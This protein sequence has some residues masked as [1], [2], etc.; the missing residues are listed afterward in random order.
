MVPAWQG[1]CRTPLATFLHGAFHS[2]LADRSTAMA[3]THR[4]KKLLGALCIGLSVLAALAVLSYTPSDNA[5]VMA[6]FEAGQM[7]HSVGVQNWLGLVG[8]ALAWA[9][10]PNFLGYLAVVPCILIGVVGWYVVRHRSLKPLTP[11][12][13]N[14]L[15]GAFL[16]AVFLGWMGLAFDLSTTRWAGA[17]GSAVAQAFVQAIGIPGTFL[18]IAGVA[19]VMGLFLAEGTMRGAMQRAVRSAQTARTSAHPYAQQA[20]RW[21]RARL[22]DTNVD[23]NAP[24]PDASSTSPAPSSD[25]EADQPRIQDPTAPQVSGLRLVRNDDKNGDEEADDKTVAPSTEADTDTTDDTKPADVGTTDTGAARAEESTPAPDSEAGALDTSPA[26]TSPAETAMPSQM[27]RAVPPP[28]SEEE[29]LD[30]KEP[31]EDADVIRFDEVRARIRAVHKRMQG[32]RRSPRQDAPR[33][34]D[35]PST[36]RTD[37]DSVDRQDAREIDT[38]PEQDA[39]ESVSASSPEAQSLSYPPDPDPLFEHAAHVVVQ[40][41]NGAAL[42]VQR[43]LVVDA[44]R[45]EHIVQQ[46]EA[47][48]IVGPPSETGRRAVHVADSDELARRLLTP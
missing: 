42:L 32:T 21:V 18:L 41:Q 1:C 22:Q 39:A 14:A 27:Q 33:E 26:D 17:V 4:K 11:H 13:Q 34:D 25:A 45:A 28:E 30:D 38:T 24:L 3:P 46:L 48:G 40:H 2:A 44:D 8:A 29:N 43:V 5:A 9:C 15:V 35:E 31:D 6:F 19:V 23:P 10:V 16:V 7:T 36:A 20:L 37:A 12:L 47:A